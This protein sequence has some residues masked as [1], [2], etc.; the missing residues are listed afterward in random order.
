LILSWLRLEVGLVALAVTELEAAAVLAVGDTE[1]QL[2]QVVG[3]QK[4][5][6]NK[7]YNLTPTMQ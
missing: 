5:S 7:S 4:P 6:Q 1:L 3:L 2:A